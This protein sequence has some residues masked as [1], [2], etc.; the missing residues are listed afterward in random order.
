[1]P[2]IYEWLF[3][4]Y[5]LPKLE[6]IRT[7]HNDALTAF[8]E[9]TG[10]SKTERLRLHDMVSNM[11]LEWGTEAFALGV[12]FGLRLNGPRIQRRDPDW[13]MYFLP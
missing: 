4:H 8:A 2:Y 11:R 12:R 7:S 6:K 9:R 1:M 13:L 3:D 10:L 5:A